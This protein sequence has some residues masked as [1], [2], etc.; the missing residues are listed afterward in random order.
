MSRLKNELFDFPCAFPIKVM[1][2]ASEDFDRLVLNIIR[3]HSVDVL[4]PAR[5]TRISRHG[6]YMSVT[7]TF[8]AY[9]RTQLDR[10]YADL[11]RHERI[12]MVL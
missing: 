9:S 12:M 7:V 8:T 1:G 10:L 4:E 5:S 11:S 6:K 2:L 3:Q